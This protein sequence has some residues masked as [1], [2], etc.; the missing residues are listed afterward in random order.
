VLDV[1]EY[2]EPSITW[3]RGSRLVK[4]RSPHR[5]PRSCQ[6]NTFD[7]GWNLAK[8]IRRI[9][10]DLEAPTRAPFDARLPR[11]EKLVGDIID[12]GNDIFIVNCGRSPRPRYPAARTPSTAAPNRPRIAFMFDFL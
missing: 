12:V 9:D 5:R 7:H 6:R 2:P 1:I 3:K 4:N 8:L 11:L 10:L